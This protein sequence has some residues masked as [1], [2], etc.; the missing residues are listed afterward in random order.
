MLSTGFDGQSL[1]CTEV[2]PVET[3]PSQPITVEGGGNSGRG[4]VSING[5]ASVSQP[6]PV[7]YTIVLA[8]PHQQH[9]QHQQHHQS[10]LLGGG[11]TSALVSTTNTTSILLNTLAQQQHQHYPQLRNQNIASGVGLTPGVTPKSAS[12]SPVTNLVV[13]RTGLSNSKFDG[14]FINTSNHANNTNV[15]AAVLA[16]PI[17][18]TRATSSQTLLI[19]TAE[20]GV[21]N[22]STEDNH[23]K[24]ATSNHIQQTAAVL[25]HGSGIDPARLGLV[26]Q[27]PEAVRG[28]GAAAS[29]FVLVTYAPA[30]SGDVKGGSAAVADIASIAQIQGLNV[31][32][33]DALRV[34]SQ[35]QAS[36]SAPISSSSSS[37]TSV[38][39]SDTI[40]VDLCKQNTE[41]LVSVSKGDVRLPVGG[42]HS[43]LAASQESNLSNHIRVLSAAV[44]SSSSSNS[45][46]ASGSTPESTKLETGP[47][48]TGAR[49][50]WTSPAQSSSSLTSHQ[51]APS[52]DLHQRQIHGSRASSPPHPSIL[53]RQQIN[54][55]RLEHRHSPDAASDGAPG[56]MHSGRAGQTGS[57][58]HPHGIS[59]SST[60][61]GGNIHHRNGSPVDCGP[62]S[63]LTKATSASP[64]SNTSSSS[65]PPYQHHQHQLPQPHTSLGMLSAGPPTIP[66]GLFRTG[67]ESPSGS[68]LPGG[69]S[70]AS[71]APSPY[72]SL[73]A[74][75][76]QP[77]GQSTAAHAHPHLQG[78]APYHTFFPGS[79]AA[80]GSLHGFAPGS[81]M[82]P[83]ASSPAGAAPGAG[84]GHPYP[85]IESYSAVLSSMGSQALQASS[86]SSLDR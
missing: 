11:T 41:V 6:Q 1:Y 83:S 60:N 12:V 62:A 44:R 31:H 25:G 40:K 27:L 69:S 33:S 68:R 51:S 52:V 48:L 49:G 55:P 80:A 37:S 20:N 21:R 35:S 71:Y 2:L 66:A 30:G 84:A 43:S 5:E 32:S 4:F 38:E 82:A 63:N 29:G 15:S 75:I 67:G 85:R 78:L 42:G 23:I 72:T 73:Y 47:I 7:Q 76:H 28:L 8:D 86:G 54:L 46:G 14:A 64:A 22:H 65:S 9:Q 56:G 50:V 74:G 45:V 36:F 10:G 13:N 59:S 18:L 3:P 58:Q 81:L 19:N 17:S 70:S 79:A 16:Y 26:E 24:V 77:G 34:L 39:P 53:Q 57:G 61:T